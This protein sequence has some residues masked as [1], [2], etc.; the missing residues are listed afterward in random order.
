MPNDL[1][2]LQQQELDKIG[3]IAGEVETALCKIEEL[4]IEADRANARLW[5]LLE[6]VKN[7]KAVKLPLD[8]PRQNCY[9]NFGAVAPL[10]GCQ[11]VI[12]RFF[13]G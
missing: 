12:S 11:V 5:E 1:F 4:A 3:S 9:N 8:R 2:L 7:R 6:A 13:E 10:R